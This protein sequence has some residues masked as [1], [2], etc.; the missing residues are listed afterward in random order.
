[1]SFCEGQNRKPLN[2]ACV[3]VVLDNQ[4]GFIQQAGKKFVSNGIFIVQE[5]AVQDRWQEST[6]QRCSWFVH[7]C[8]IGTWFLLHYLPRS[9]RGRSLT[10]TG[11]TR[12]IF[13][14]AAGVL[15]FKTRR[16]ETETKLNQTQENLDRLED[17][18]YE[19]EG[20]IN[21][22]KSKRL[23]SSFLELDQNGRFSSRCFSC[24]SRSDKRALR[25]G[26]SKKKKPFRTVGF[27]LPTS[28]GLRRR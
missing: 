12:A 24:S 4:D 21:L 3:T 26:W 22:L 5:T 6:S 15:K 8:G 23:S 11:R 28:S 20:Q 7:G 19:L 2:Y 18:L 10:Q 9:G 17:I 13:E 1:M 25:K 27:L 14:E 16:K